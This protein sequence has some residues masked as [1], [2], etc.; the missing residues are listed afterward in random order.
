MDRIV[1]G[2]DG[3]DGS[4]RALAWAI[5]EAR[6]RGDTTVEVVHAWEP[7]VLTGSPVGEVPPVPVDSAFDDAAHLLIADALTHVDTTGVTVEQVVVEGPSGAALCEHA[8][9]AALLVVSASGHGKVLEA[10]I[11]SVSGYC[12]HHARCPLVITP[13]QK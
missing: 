8:A 12:V 10:L 3:S 2:V 4:G 13:K 9:D 7:P 11:G 1:V 6:R 5:D